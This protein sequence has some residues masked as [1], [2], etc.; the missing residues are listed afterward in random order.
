[1]KNRTFLFSALLI[2][3]RACGGGHSDFAFAQITLPNAVPMPTPEIQYLDAAGAPLAG[4]KLCTYAAG[5]STPLATYTSSTAGTPNTNPIILDSAGRASVWVGPKLYKFVL[6]TGGDATCSTGSI[7]WTQDNVADTTLYFTNYVKTVGTASLIST[8]APY[9][10]AVSRT[11]LSKNNDIVNVTDFGA[12]CDGSTDDTD[13]INAAVTGLTNGGQIN[14][15][16]GTCIISAAIV[17]PNTG[18][19]HRSYTLIGAGYNS[20]TIEQTNISAD[21]ISSTDPI[22]P[23]NADYFVLRDMHIKGPGSGTGIGINLTD[24]CNWWAI[25]NVLVD[26]FGG[27]GIY[28]ANGNT[29]TVYNVISDQNGGNG[30]TLS[31][32]GL[33]GSHAT[34]VMAF[35]GTN[36]GHDGLYAEYLVDLS[37]GAASTFE[38]NLN[39]GV[40]VGQGAG[41]PTVRDSYF[42]G[43]ASAGVCATGGGGG[44]PLNGTVTSSYFIGQPIHIHLVAAIG[45]QI[46]GNFP[47]VEGSPK[48]FVQLEVGAVLTYVGIQ[49]NTNATALVDNGVA[50]LYQVNDTRTFRQ[51]TKNFDVVA[52]ALQAGLAGDGTVDSPL[53]TY[54]ASGQARWL[55]RIGTHFLEIFRNAS[56]PLIF[57]NS[58]EVF[59][60][61]TATDEF[62]TGLRTKLE[63]SDNAV[64]VSN[65]DPAGP[66][67]LIVVATGAQGSTPMADFQ[68]AGNGVQVSGDGDLKLVGNASPPTCD[69]TT[70]GRFHYI[71][72]ATGIGAADALWMCAKKADDTYQWKVITWTP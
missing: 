71:R 33:I 2:L 55:N 10:G 13:A 1:M 53:E 24:R 34:T 18:A 45:W 47:Q 44:S 4:S 70:R 46:Y 72:Q 41:V 17:L 19:G 68:I 28:N 38:N 54:K 11:Q 25:Q 42:E 57:W 22:N 15:P 8:L 12:L 6:R 40:E 37:I 61:G 35:R 67:E 26:F 20:T 31:Q 3:L 14:F 5:T 32:T 51:M 69:A 16:Q 27:D 59:K 56:N 62:G 64:T 66:S 43:N 39:C 52:G 30:L 9:T 58:G 60:L 63:V 36:N 50:T 49:N 65:S 7:A 48:I 29:G 23:G 21:G